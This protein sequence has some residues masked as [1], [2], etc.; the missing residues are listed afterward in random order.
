MKETTPDAALFYDV[1]VDS[2]RNRQ[3]QPGKEPYRSLPGD[4]LLFI[5]AKPKSISDLQRSGRAWALASITKI[6]GDDKT[7]D[8][9][10]ANFKVKVEEPCNL[11][12]IRNQISEENLCPSSELNESQNKTIGKTITLSMLLWNLLQKQFRILT[13]VPMSVVIAEVI[14]HTLKVM[15]ESIEAGDGRDILVCSVANILLFGNKEKLKVSPDVEEVFL[16]YRAEKLAEC[17]GPI[18]GWKPC[19]TS[20]IEFLEGCVSEYEVLRDDQSVNGR[21]SNGIDNRNVDRISFL[22]FLKDKFRSSSIALKRCVSS[23]CTHVLVTYIKKCNID[24]MIVLV[25]SLDSFETLLYRDDADSERL[26][27]LFSIPESFDTSDSFQD[28]FRVLC[29]RRKCLSAL[30]KL[31]AHL[32]N[33][34]FQL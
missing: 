26:K 7:D 17:F 16:D 10:S 28:E 22:E 29:L 25:D 33:L 5:E 3:I 13:Y 24:S 21:R 27:E 23:T 34:S 8:I 12:P 30:R 2:W 14:S 1:E 20:M 18:T 4:M 11:C 9:I 32:T 19:F 6:S 15:R 31:R